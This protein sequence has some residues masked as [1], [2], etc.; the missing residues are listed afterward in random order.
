MSSGSSSKYE[1]SEAELQWEERRKA[2][3]TA[4]PNGQRRASEAG[5]KRL[6]R[7]FNPRNDAERTAAKPS[8]P[9]T[10]PFRRYA[11]H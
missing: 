2:W 5:I 11:V 7:L 8:E 1:P 6:D 3:L 4:T 10:L 9:K